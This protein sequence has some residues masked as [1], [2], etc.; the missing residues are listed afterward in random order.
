VPSNGHFYT[1]M[2]E[3]R[4]G[5]NPV[6]FLIANPATVLDPLVAGSSLTWMDLG[7]GTPLGFSAPFVSWA[8]AKQFPQGALIFNPINAHFYTAIVGGL[9]GSVMPGFPVTA[10]LTV[11]E[12]QPGPITWKEIGTTAP[13]GSTGAIPQWTPNTSFAAGQ[14]VNPLNGHFYVAAVGGQSGPA[15][16]GW[17]TTSGATVLDVPVVV[18]A[19]TWMDA[20]AGTPPG[21]SSPFAAWSAG[22]QFAP[23]AVI[24]DAI[25]GH[26]YIAVVGGQ[27]GT[28]VPMFPITVPLTVAETPPAQITW[29][30]VGTTAPS[31]LPTTLSQWTPNTGFA[32][33]QV[34]SDPD[35][36]HFYLA[37]IGGQSGSTLPVF[38]IT[39]KPQIVDGQVLFQD[40][41]SAPPA[42]LASAG[43]TD[44]V[45]SLLNTPLPQVHAL[46]Y[47]NLASGVVYGHITTKNF[48]FQSPPT[49]VILCTTTTLPPPCPVAT[50]GAPTVDPV[51][52][53][54]GYIKPMDAESPYN[55]K[56][57]F[58]R[59][60]GIT[61]GLS[62]SSPANNY[63]VGGSSEFPTRNVQLVYGAIFAKVSVLAPPGAQA[64]GTVGGTPNTVQT[65]KTGWFVGFTYNIS[66]F[67]QSL[68]P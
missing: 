57:D 23:G 5:T 61:F 1:A 17:P 19:L 64:A 9:S 31:S 41:G 39:V 51:L 68:I 55:F 49:G 56:R 47:F 11:T 65:F 30:D 50:N 3:G 13:A 33:G 26:F 63:Y 59:W 12:P 32:T 45:V 14:V 35:N 29:E 27:T 37:R 67:I 7:T 4:S 40:S 60:P 8:P 2:N 44:Q 15:V 66:G 6:T 46:Y 36:G 34:I 48:S 43:P 18:G 21:F 28:T 38:P 42:S 20:G 16:P 52:L 25:N 24:L 62:L 54:T 22:K 10:R 53:F 58:L